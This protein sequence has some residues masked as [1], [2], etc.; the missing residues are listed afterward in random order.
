MATNEEKKWY[1]VV[2]PHPYVLILF[3]IIVAAL[4]T[5]IIP[6]G[7]FA[8]VLNPATGKK[9]V[10]AG[11]FKIIPQHP[12]S[13]GTLLMSV[14][15][16]L[17]AAADIVFYVLIIGGAFG[18]ILETGAINALLAKVVT[19]FG[20]RHEKRVIV[21]ITAFF[22][23]CAASFGMYGESLVFTPFLVVL[24]ISMGYDAIVGVSMTMVAV[25]AGY[26]CAFLNPFTIGLAQGIAGLPL[27]SGLLF[28]IAF[29]AVFMS[30]TIWYILRYAVKVKNDPSS[31]L[32]KDIDYSDL[33]VTDDPTKMVLTA[34]HMRVLF[35]FFGSLVVL[36][37]GAI[38]FNFFISH[39]ASLFLIMGI[40]VGL[41]YGMK[42]GDIADYFIKGAQ[43]MVYAALIVGVA[44]GIMVVMEE[45][46]IMDSVV[47][48]LTQPLTALP[49]YLSAAFMVPVQSLINFFV[50]SGSGQAMVSIPI[51]APIGDLLGISRQVTVLAYHIGDG[52]TNVIIPTNGPLMAGIAMG[53]IPYTK[54]VAFVAK[55]VGIQMALGMLCV[56]VA[57]LI[58]LG[59]F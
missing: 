32:V 42:S 28:R 27:F 52:I 37:I 21:F 31:S 10:E 58:G 7:E 47:Y 23:L 2:V 13:M 55:L 3:I 59:P 25:S 15:L 43:S 36:V 44:R 14:Q 22:G 50:P 4:A 53:R 41:V 1:H 29:F 5:Y 26:A 51:M 40:L 33:A 39:L 48:Y 46:R 17:I 6:A 8:R 11:S 9:V 20:G 30:V 49:V 57:V 12:V 35:V 16:G 34:G 38:K 18:V 45:G 54:W 56:V 19:R 24:A